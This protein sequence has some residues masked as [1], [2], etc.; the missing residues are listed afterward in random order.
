MEGGWDKGE[1]FPSVPFSPL[2][3][4]DIPKQ[5][6]WELINRHAPPFP[7]LSFIQSYYKSLIMHLILKIQILQGKLIFEPQINWV[8]RQSLGIANLKP[9]S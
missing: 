5:E 6:E 3:L 2:H 9:N 1:M 7:S 4:I 8:Q